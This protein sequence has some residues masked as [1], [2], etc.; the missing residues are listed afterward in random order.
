[1][2]RREF[3]AGL[4]GAAVWPLTARAQQ[5]DRVR[6]VGVLMN[7]AAT[8]TEIQ[9]D[10]AAFVQGLRQLGWTEGQNLHIEVRWNNG[11]AALARTFAA[12]LIGLTP[13]VILTASTVN[14]TMV[15]QVTSTVPVVFVGVADPVTQGAP[16][17]IKLRTRMSLKF[18]FESVR[19]D[20]LRDEIDLSNRAVVVRLLT[21]LALMPPQYI[22]RDH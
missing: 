2:K 11:D 7:G 8:E 17:R 4:G 6:R 19:L 1:V 3:I 16:V 12:E 15:Q 5:S 22:S 18:H 14:L 13:D 9:A 20:R 21:P 10:Q